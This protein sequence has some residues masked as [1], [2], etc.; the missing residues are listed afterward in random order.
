MKTIERLEKLL[1]AKDEELQ[2]LREKLEK[3]EDAEGRE[4]KWC[5][6]QEIEAATDSLPVPR[7]ECRAKMVGDN[8][9]NFVWEYSLI[10]R[11]FLKHIMKIP[12]GLTTTNSGRGTPPVFNGE[13]HGP[14]REG[15]H[16]KSDAEELGLP[17]FYIVETNPV[18][19]Q[20]IVKLK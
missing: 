6:P 12:L 16:I 8:W 1:D 17:A 9:H 13:I 11:H 4:W 19:I 10:Y 20:P 5:I 3:L 2:E 15:A 7:L 14:F 18:T